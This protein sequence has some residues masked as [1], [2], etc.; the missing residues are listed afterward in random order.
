MLEGYLERSASKLP[1]SVKNLRV[2]CQE[3]HPAPFIFIPQNTRSEMSRA[4]SDEIIFFN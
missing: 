3:G 1:A 2:H 4:L